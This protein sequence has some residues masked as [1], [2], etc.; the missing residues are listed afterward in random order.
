MTSTFKHLSLLTASLLFMAC[1]GGG[2]S[3]S[4]PIQRPTPIPLSNTSK[5]I[6]ISEY[7]Q[8]E[9]LGKNTN[10]K[11]T[12]NIEDSPKSVYVLLS[13]SSETRASLPKITHN[14]VA[15]TQRSQKDVSP[16]VPTIHT[17][18][19]QH[20]PAYIQ[21]FNKNVKKHLKNKKIIKSEKRT[22][23]TLIPQKKDVEN[24]LKVFYIENNTNKSTSA[25]ARKI[26]TDVHTSFGNKTLNIWVSNDSFGSDCN[27]SK[28]VTQEM[29]DALAETFLKTGLNNDIYDWVTNIYGEEWNAAAENKYNYVIGANNEITILLT[30]IE[31]DDKSNG[32]TTGYFHAKDNVK[33][34]NI[35]ASNERVMFYIDSVMFANGE[36]TWDINDYWPKE[37]V[38]TLVHE[39]VHMIDYFQKTVIIG[40]DAADT[41]FS[42]MLAETTEDL[43]ATKIGH[44]GPRGVEHADGTAGS[45]ENR[46]GRYGL[47]N[48]NNTLSLSTWTGALADYSKVS[49][50]GTYLTRNY[51]GAKVMHDIMHN[52]Y[53]D[54]E[55]IVNAVRKSPQGEEKTFADLQKEWGIAVL[56]SDQENLVDKPTYNTG[57]FTNTTYNEVTYELGSINFFN[58]SDQPKISTSV[59]KVQ[60]QGNYYYKVG[61]NLTGT[62]TIDLTLDATTSATLIVK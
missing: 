44:I 51:G 22:S 48:K 59:G 58:Y 20:A 29:V 12:V 7:N 31:N 39:F 37:I 42:E 13:N 33:K 41:W 27:K 2:A 56:L 53:S 45:G 17:K 9:Y 38:S 57:E 50:F 35:S 8:I 6:S 52:K 30:D 23:T 11:T 43:V 19:G 25:T 1:D 10:V 34:T 28:C 15:Q 26:V 55:A 4:N 21:A 47:F 60:P 54:T 32:G 3:N 40:G 14:K 5:N 18:R 49:A 24:D 36:D 16:V 62:V 46:D 61:D